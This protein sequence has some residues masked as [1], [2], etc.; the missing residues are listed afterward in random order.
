MD[1]AASFA[2]SGGPPHPATASRL[3]RRRINSERYFQSDGRYTSS[4]VS[5]AGQT[6]LGYPQG[7]FISSVTSVLAAAVLNPANGIPISADA[8]Y[9]LL[10]S[11]DVS[12]GQLCASYCG[13][14][15]YFTSGSTPLKYAFIGAC[16]T[17]V[18]TPGPLASNPSS[19]PNGD[20]FGADSMASVIVHEVE[21][22]A[23]DPCAA[24]PAAVVALAYDS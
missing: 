1:T 3:L 17:G 12:E 13:Y 14:H 5:V 15:S 8:Q 18:C 7:T 24:P 20:L 11:P 10:A 9:I 6:Y 2:P 21:E 19:T 23:T 16:Q 4:T 22:T